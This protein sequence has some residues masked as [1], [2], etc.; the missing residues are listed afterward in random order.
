MEVL[1]L[2]MHLTKQPVKHRSIV[3]MPSVWYNYYVPIIITTRLWLSPMLRNQGNELVIWGAYTTL[4]S[5]W[6]CMRITMAT[7]HDYNRNKSAGYAASYSIF[8]T[9]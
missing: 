8:N 1:A 2:T 3:S 9:Y 7:I 6:T 4:I 5:Y